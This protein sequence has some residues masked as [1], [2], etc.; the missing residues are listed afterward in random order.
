M[1]GAISLTLRHRRNTKHQ[2]VTQQVNTQPD[3]V[4]ELV[5]VKTG[6]GI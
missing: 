6:A 1:I 5:K 4:V 2:N 3:D